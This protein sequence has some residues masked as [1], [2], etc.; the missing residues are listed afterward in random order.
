[1]DLGHLSD[2]IFFQIV[3]KRIFANL[4]PINSYLKG[5]VH[6]FSMHV[7]I[8]KYFL[9][10]PEKNLAQTGLVVLEKYALFNSE[11]WRH[12]AEG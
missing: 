3:F 4:N 2:W 6:C 7:V 8:N 10:N 1:M 5:R 9:L 12:R 11:K